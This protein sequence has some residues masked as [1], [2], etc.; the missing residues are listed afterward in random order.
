MNSTKKKNA[1]SAASKSVVSL[2]IE[3]D[4]K[5]ALR[6]VIEAAGGVV[7]V[8]Y[9]TVSMLA[10]DIPLSSL[11]DVLAS[12]HALSIHKNRLQW[13]TDEGDGIT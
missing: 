13:L 9:M 11:Q 6:N 3:T 4:D 10:A 1:P 7:T 5:K 2:I 12:P 8:E